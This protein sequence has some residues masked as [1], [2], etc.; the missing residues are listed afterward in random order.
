MMINIVTTVLLAETPIAEDVHVAVDAPDIA[1]VITNATPLFHC[2][3]LLSRQT[4]LFNLPAPFFGGACGTKG[5]HVR[6][7]LFK[8]LFNLTI[9]VVQ[10]HFTCR[11]FN[12]PSHCTFLIVALVRD[13]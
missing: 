12:Y 13:T 9:L 4:L 2:L 10:L 11:L 6:L 1:I 5:R 3:F 7:E 8:T